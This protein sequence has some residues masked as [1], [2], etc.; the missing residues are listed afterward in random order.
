LL[1][2]GLHFFQALVGS[3]RL[4]RV[5]GSEGSDAVDLKTCAGLILRGMGGACQSRKRSGIQNLNML[6][7]RMVRSFHQVIQK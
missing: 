7:D 2:L 4:P 5:R 1:M 3:R 6:W